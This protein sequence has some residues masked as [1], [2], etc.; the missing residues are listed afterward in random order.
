MVHL[1]LSISV[2]ERVNKT[3][4]VFQTILQDD[5][6]KGNARIFFKLTVILFFWIFIASSTILFIPH[7]II[8]ILLIPHNII[9]QSDSDYRSLWHILLV[10]YKNNTMIDPVFLYKIN[11]QS[12]KQ[13]PSFIYSFFFSTS[14][15]TIPLISL[16]FN[17]LSKMARDGIIIKPTQVYITT[18]SLSGIGV[19]RFKNKAVIQRCSH[20]LRIAHSFSLITYLFLSHHL[21]I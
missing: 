6:R 3:N 8:T 15:T 18:R 14:V 1:L 17:F 7:N 4:L 11:E 21:L 2:H 13:K 10:W 20:V 9:K 5:R 16:S 12:R 19:K